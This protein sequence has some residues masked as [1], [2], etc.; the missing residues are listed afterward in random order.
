MMTPSYFQ[1]LVSG[2]DYHPYLCDVTDLS[3]PGTAP[4]FSVSTGSYTGSTIFLA[5]YDS[6]TISFTGHTLQSSQCD[7]FGDTDFEYMIVPINTDTYPELTDDD[8]YPGLF[9]TN[10]DDTSFGVSL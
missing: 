1:S 4:E 6:A 10:I 8:I 5:N 7:D 2:L 3:Q 9:F